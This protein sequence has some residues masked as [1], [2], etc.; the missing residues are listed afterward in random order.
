M[1]AWNT[2]G[3]FLWLAAILTLIAG[4]A[5]QAGT[6]L[7]NDYFDHRTGTDAANREFV[8]PFSGG[9]R[10]IELGLMTPSETLLLGTG[11]C[12]LSG[13]IG[14]LLAVDGRPWVLALGVAG[15][16]SGVLYTAKPFAWASRGFGELLVATN[17]GVLMT[18]GAYYVQAG[19]MTWEAALASLPVAG[20][21]ALVLYVNEFPDYNSDARSGKRT[22]VVRLGRARAALLYPVLGA[23]PFVAVVA[24][25]ATDYPPVPS[26]AALVALVLI[27]RA[28]L[29]VLRNYEKPFDMAPANA[30]TAIGHLAGGLLFALGYA[31]D[32]LGRDGLPLA[33]ALGVV[34]VGYVLFMYRSVE[35]QRRVFDGVKTVL[36]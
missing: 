24:L 5:I 23:L 22:L 19:E 13:A 29:I 16:L 32:E 7:F 8:R 25:V 27:V 36:G 34:G 18:L 1:V 31:W 33:I 11:L 21:I 28:S 12:A 14:V 30:L 17:Y 6:N 2:T 10:M 4:V 35:R 26:L 15:L 3:E 9:S 20:L